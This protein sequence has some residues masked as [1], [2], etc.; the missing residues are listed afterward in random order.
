MN[1]AHI[2]TRAVIDLFITYSY[3]RCGCFH[4]VL[5]VSV[6]KGGGGGVVP[7]FLEVFLDQL[8]KVLC[9]AFQICESLSLATILVKNMS[10]LV[11]RLCQNTASECAVLD[12][13]PR[14]PHSGTK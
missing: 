9:K 12:P 5:V 10:C 14:L 2:F 11:T 1:I 3:I 7:H 13:P 4:C 8:E 6:L